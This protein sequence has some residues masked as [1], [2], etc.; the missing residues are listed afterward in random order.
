MRRQSGVT[1]SPAIKRLKWQGSQTALKVFWT[2]SADEWTPQ[3]FAAAVYGRF[4]L[5]ALGGAARALQHLKRR[6]QL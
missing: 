4:D 5:A 6:A 3:S 1:T 2:K